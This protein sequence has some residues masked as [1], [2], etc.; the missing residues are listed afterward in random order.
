VVFSD[1]TLTVLLWSAIAATVS[2]LALGLPPRT[3]FAG[4]SGVKLIVARN[5]IRHPARP[6]D[7]DLPR[8]DG[9]VAPFV[10][11]FFVV[12]GDHAHAATPDV[13]PLL[14]APFIA[15]LGIRGDLVVPAAGFL[16]AI[17]FIAALGVELDDR[18]SRTWLLLV[19][20]VC[21][22]LLFYGLEFWEHAPAAALAAAGTTLYVRR[23]SARML[24]A[25]GA[26]LAGSVLLRPEA[27]CYAV[28]LV[29]ASRWLRGRFIAIEAATVAAGALLVLLPL[30]VMST[31]ASGQLFGTHIARNS[32]ALL[33]GWWMNRWAYLREWLLPPRNGWLAAFVVLVLASVAASTGSDS[34]RKAIVRV[35]GVA[36]AAVVAFAAAIGTFD[37]AS[38][39]NAA[40]A[41][42]AAFAIP[43]P[44]KRRGAQ[45]L[46]VLAGVSFALV[47]LVV[48]SDG[49]AQWGP[50]F[51]TLSFI[52]LAILLADAFAAT[53]S[54]SS[55]VGTVAVAVAIA[56]SLT[57]QRRSY[58]D[59]WGSKDMYE[60][61]VEFVERETPT[62][63]LI[64]T[65]VWWF[66][67][68]T[69]GLYPT[70]Q[71]MVADTTESVA[72]VWQMLAAMPRVYLVRSDADSSDG[73]A[74]RYQSSGFIPTRRVRVADRSLELI[75]LSRTISQ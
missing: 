19:A 65:D 27:I 40:P 39:W 56:L 51:A 21:T 20:A 15:L 72:M 9:K 8:V 16:A 55:V 64:V 70:R 35:A 43:F 62:G 33:P 68:I 29:V 58:R 47:A 32:V 13:F 7:V 67:S 2:I 14:S 57:V 31:L 50:R 17:W 71:V 49:G 52:P 59:L 34:R 60:R 11:R 75:E 46:W 3:F 26:L 48:P 22:P 41:M 5:A 12:H 44:N 36:F 18:R 4:D 10:D 37:R 1:R 54:G 53:V 25:S 66:D 30:A 42:V 6:L 74:A 23:Q 38:V 61:I 69:A 24:A 45:F 28:A 73:F 63:S